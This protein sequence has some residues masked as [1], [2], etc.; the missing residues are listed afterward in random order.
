METQEPLWTWLKFG[1]FSNQT[2]KSLLN[3]VI[4]GIGTSTWFLSSSCLTE[5]W[6]KWCSKL[7]SAITSNGSVL[8]EVTCINGL[9]EECFHQLED[10]SRKF[11]E[12]TG[13][14]LSLI[15]WVSLRRGD[16]KLYLSSS[17]GLKRKTRKPIK[18]WM[19]IRWLLETLLRP[20]VLRV[21]LLISWDMQLLFTLITLSLVET[22]LR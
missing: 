21:T 5:S 16:V 19:L 4:I 12:M 18:E 9:K 11:L 1:K 6:S 14:L 13:K 17:K 22:V 2:N 7:R 20:M 10:K 15:S 3:W 8:M